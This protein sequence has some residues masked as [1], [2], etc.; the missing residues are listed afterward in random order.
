MTPEQIA[1]WEA[2]ANAETDLKVKAQMLDIVAHVRRDS[3]S[4]EAVTAATEFLHGAM[5][6]YTAP[7]PDALL[8]Q[9]LSILR[10]ELGPLIERLFATHPRMEVM[11]A[12][13]IG[14]LTSYGVLDV[15]IIAHE[16]HLKAQ[17]A[18]ELLLNDCRQFIFD[19][20]DQHGLDLHED[21]CDETEDC[22]C[23]RIKQ[24]NDLLRGWVAK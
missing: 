24:A 3:G 8:E 14:L 11:L 5:K 23:P 4:I 20:F 17:A 12:H 18:T 1:L 6:R 7:K 21:G 19:A 16:E 13:G 22:G 9:Q 2:H 10:N 15:V